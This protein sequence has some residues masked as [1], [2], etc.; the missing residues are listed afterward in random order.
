M[1]DK[2]DGTLSP[3]GERELEAL[4]AERPEERV[5][6]DA[7]LALRNDVRAL[8]RDFNPD[9]AERLS[10]V[11]SRTR[12][13]IP[14][15]RRILRY[16]AG[17]ALLVGLTGVML[18]YV[19]SGGGGDRDFAGVTNPGGNVAILMLPGGREYRL[20]ETIKNN[21]VD[22]EGELRIEVDRQGVLSYSSDAHA[23][24]DIT[25]KLITPRGGDYSLILEDGTEVWLNS[26][27][28]LEF[29][30]RFGSAQRR[31]SLTGEGYFRVSS[32]AARPFI[33]E[34][35][36]VSVEVIGTEF[37]VSA[38][39]G[40]DDIV[41]TLVEGSVKLRT[42]EGQTMLRPGEQGVYNGGNMKVREVDT[43]Y[44]TS[45]VDGIYYFD[46]ESLAHIAQQMA[47]WYDVEFVFDTPRLKDV[48][49]SGSMKKDR[50][51]D[52]L[53]HRMEATGN[54][55]FRVDGDVIVISE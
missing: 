10:K 26:E 52:E 33:V 27:S 51:I 41:T 14:L 2:L 48:R 3:E 18:H 39:S 8:K 34:A 25:L 44:Y 9:M 1:I 50:P 5:L 38:L 22:I 24:E 6:Y 7:L 21:T 45:W 32:D 12:R 11:K 20:D 30:K 54:L 36:G 55:R 19:M 53:I 37:N 40:T 23:E 13:T 35:G 46:N 4:L 49:F 17:L 16:A 15:N 47:R 42:A 43:S 29:P 28:R 31:V